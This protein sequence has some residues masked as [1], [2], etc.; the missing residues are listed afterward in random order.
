[1]TI[2][3]QYHSLFF[4]KKEK[5]KKPQNYRLLKIADCLQIRYIFLIRARRFRPALVSRLA[6]GADKNHHHHHNHH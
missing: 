1:M 3:K 6:I 5:E 2:D 4:G